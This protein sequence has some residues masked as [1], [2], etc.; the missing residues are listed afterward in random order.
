VPPTNL[1]HALFNDHQIAVRARALDGGCL[2]VTVLRAERV[3]RQPALQ[4]TQEHQVRVVADAPWVELA[5]LPTQVG[6][7][8]AG[9]LLLSFSSSLLHGPSQQPVE[10]SL[11]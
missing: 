2:A 3:A 10:V 11:I 9:Q 4:V 7:M 1:L 8:Y 6:M 5:A